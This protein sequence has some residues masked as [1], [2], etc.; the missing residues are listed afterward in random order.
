MKLTDIHEQKEQLSI[1]ITGGD[2]L[3]RGVRPSLG[4]RNELK[5][6]T[7]YLTSGFLRK[8]N[9]MVDGKQI[10]SQSMEFKIGVTFETNEDRI[11]AVKY[12]RNNINTDY[13][14]NVK[15]Y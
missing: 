12:L 14:R 11:N 8:F 1:L 10:N 5:K 15:S 4:T 6:L 7:D 9:G 3:T 13:I 2:Y